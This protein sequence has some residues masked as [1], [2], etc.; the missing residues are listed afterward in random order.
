MA[1]HKKFPTK[2]ARRLVRMALEEDLAGIGD[3]TT[4]ALIPKGSEVRA[5]V[6]A[7]EAGILAGG[8]VAAL[9]FA[10]LSKK[11]KVRQLKK[12][13]ARFKK[14][15]RLL[16]ITGPAR[17]ILTGERT[18]L[19]FLRHL[20]GIASATGKFADKCKGTKARIYDTRK[21]TPGL[22]ALEKYAVVCGGGVNHRFGLFDAVL[23]KD[24]HIEVAGSVELAVARARK[25]SPGGTPIQVE[26]DTLAQVRAALAAR[27]D[28]ILCD[29]MPP[30]KLKQAVA[31]VGGACPVEASGGVNLRTVAGI[32]K[33]GV[34]RI[35]VGAITHSAPQVDLALDF[36]PP[37][38]RRRGARLKKPPVTT[39]ARP[40]AA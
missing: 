24:N 26:C 3:L 36:V 6:V 1:K 31:I 4:R 15:D 30:A 7:R 22:R 38:P 35:S 19:N 10:G 9:T 12:D 27:P 33:S 16:E 20:S 21:T 8:P 32:A 25:K 29:N 14:G 18:A 13:G 39:K 17:P 28:M 11:V 34:E 5:F 40:R 37:K 23:I 2:Q